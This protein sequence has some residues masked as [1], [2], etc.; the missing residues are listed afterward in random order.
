M[1]DNVCFHNFFKGILLILLR[2]P[3]DIGDRVCFVAPN[4][5][6]NNDGPAGGGWIIEKVDLYTTTVRLGSTKEYATLSNGSLSESR[7]IN[8]KRS[9]NPVIN[10]YLKFTIDVTEDQLAVFRERMTEYVK[11]RPREWVKIICFRCNRV[12]TELQYIEYLMQVQH[13]EVKLRKQPW[14]IVIVPYD[15]AHTII[16]SL[17]FL[18]LSLSL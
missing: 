2:R 6:V 11:G 10:L 18:C 16:R 3:Y 5:D 14:T 15:I 12:E 9:N 17:F 7:I 13:R 1:A 4:A 8:L